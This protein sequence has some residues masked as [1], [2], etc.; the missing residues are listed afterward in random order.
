MTDKS[1][2]NRR[3]FLKLAGGT[4]AALGLAEWRGTQVPESLADS[5]DSNII[6]HGEI[7]DAKGATLKMGCWAGT[8]QQFMDQ[9]ALNQ[10]K[11]DFNCQISYDTAFPWFPKFAAHGPQNPV[12]DITN[13]NL[14][15]LIQTARTGDYFVSI[16]EFKANVPNA[17][18][19]WP[20][21]TAN[22]RGITYLISQYGY[23]YRKDK[24]PAPHH[25][26]D[27]W[28]P[29]YHGKR[30]T[31][32]PANTLEQVFFMVTSYVYG[33]SPENINAG[34]AATRKAMP[35]VISDFTGS[36]QASLSRG[37]VDIAVLDDGEAYQLEDKGLPIGFTYW[38]EKKPILDQTLTVSKH[39]SPMQKRLAFALANR[40]LSPG[41]STKLAKANYYRPTN[42]LAK[43]SPTLAKR[44][45]KNS[46]SQT[47]G[48]WI[49]PFEWYVAH[50]QEISTALDQIFGK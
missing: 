24:V 37:E 41:V 46:A 43:L 33:G 1:R 40:I 16:S 21:A 25:F 39:S 34:L 11:K 5:A 32:I 35:M 9:Y 23:A 14:P 47:R 19:L 17:K 15:D 6:Y 10:F 2:L 27:F 8:Y 28:K 12:F 45:L 7:F 20:F 22:G 26:K 38:T 4:A 30:G 31:Y 29:V 50:Q 44:G 18:H 48:L 36:I 42:R 49:P 3:D 13:W